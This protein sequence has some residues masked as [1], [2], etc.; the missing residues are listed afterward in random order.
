M[1]RLLIAGA[2]V[3]ALAALPLIA[4]TKMDHSAHKMAGMMSAWADGFAAANAAMHA[5]MA[6]EY[7][8][9]ADMDFARGMIPHHQ[10]A[11]D[12]AAVELEFGT[13]P[14]MRKL[15]Q[16]VVAAQQVEIAFMQAW[17]AKHGG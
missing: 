9:S 5:G 2:G 7:S 1:K 4:Q 10:G 8:D 16:G 12:M 11:V 15:A 6:I 3:L 13:D 14:E 17:I